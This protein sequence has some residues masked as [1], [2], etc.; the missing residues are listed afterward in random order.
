MAQFVA[1]PRRLNP[2]SNFKFL[3]K[4]DGQYVAGVSK[5]SALKRTTEVIEHRAGG[6]PSSPILAPGRTK[7][8]PLTL[9]RGLTY[10]R[11]FEAW[12]A[13]GF[14]FNAGLGLEVS[15]LDFRKDLLIEH[16]DEAGRVTFRYFVSRA[17]VSEY[18]AMAEHDAN[19]NAVLIES[20]VLQNE[21]WDR[22]TSATEQL[23]PSFNSTHA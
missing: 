2:Y 23:E 22:D 10:D 9:E 5:F 17:W 11:A 8:A 18:Q 4:W 3:V 13:K 7:F 21:G 6:D 12:A 16:L 1:N 15:L 20:M 19:Q 14:N